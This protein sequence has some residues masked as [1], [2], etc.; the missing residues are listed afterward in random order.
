MNQ[1]FNLIFCFW[2][3]DLNQNRIK[4]NFSMRSG[5]FFFCKLSPIYSYIPYFISVRNAYQRLIGLKFL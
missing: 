3:S 5:S 2:K 1:I 4:T